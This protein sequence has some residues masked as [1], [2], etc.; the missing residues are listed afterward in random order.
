MTRALVPLAI[1]LLAAAA[2]AQ[3]AGLSPSQLLA[4]PGDAP[5]ATE[6][7]PPP[8]SYAD[9][10]Q[11]PVPPPSDVAP[12]PRAPDADGVRI[13][14][15]VT[16]RLRAL[17]ANLQSLASRGGGNIVNAIL[18]LLT[19]G[20]AITVG[21]IDNGPLSPYLYIYG[22]VAAVRGVLDFVLTPNASGVAITYQHMPMT[23]Q[24]EIRERLEYGERAL[25]GLAEQSLIARIL[26]ASLNMAA[27]VAAVPAFLAVT[28]FT[29][30]N[31]ID[32]F[33][34]IGAGISVVT[35]I[36]ALASPSAA[37]QRW[38]AYV[39]L[40]ERL[41][42]EQREEREARGEDAQDEDLDELALSAPAARWSLSASPLGGSFAL[43]F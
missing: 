11:Y 39:D 33:V 23:T 1:C 20:L 8:P 4:P 28:D 36:I 17:D 42:R 41:R 22:G 2:S 24:A 21:I 19:G 30:S 9:Q 15:R 27:G 32:Y 26:D 35:G 16:T 29:F 6:A 18:S 3:P 43:A 31:P 37:E 7:V 10:V 25:S 34:L 13:P 38:G 5:A 40:R 14:S 12:S